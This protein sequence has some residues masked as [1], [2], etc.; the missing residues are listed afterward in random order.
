M[1]GDPVADSAEAAYVAAVRRRLL[2]GT[3]PVPGEWRGYLDAALVRGVWGRPVLTPRQRALISVAALAALRCPG[4]LR[5]HA[6]AALD[7]G[8]TAA[9]LCEAL[10]Q[11]VGYGGLGAGM[12]ALA[13]TGDLLGEPGTDPAADPSGD[14]GDWLGRGE[15]ILLALR[16]DFQGHLY[17]VPDG[18]P[19][20]WRDWLP[21]WQRW[22][23]G[24]AFGGLYGRRLLSIDER[25]RVTF[26]VIVALG[27]E[28][29]LRQ[30]VRICVSLGIPLAEI[31]EEIM[32]L[33]AYAGFPAA[34]KAIRVATET[35]TEDAA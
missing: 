2:D 25:E 16:P 12:A 7:L 27:H 15:Q 18:V 10:L 35:L 28:G 32:H 19:P 31:G 20:G 23:L 3:P 29:E 11:V 34:V 6:E 33:A 22:L 9:E 13:A 1:T 26:A 21:H 17:D 24:A 8:V 14:A 5:A 30:H 4:L